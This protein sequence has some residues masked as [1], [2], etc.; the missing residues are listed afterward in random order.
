MKSR[1]QLAIGIAVAAALV[2]FAVVIWVDRMQ[3]VTITITSPTEAPISVSITGAVR[4][5]GVVEVPAGSRLQ[6]V[7]EA[8]GG[9]RDDA[10]T[11]RLNMAGRVG[12]GEQIDI[13]VVGAAEAAQ[14]ERQATGDLIDLNTATISELDDLPGIGEVLAGRIIDYRTTNGPFTA[15]DEL[16]N[17]EGISPRLVDE[18]RPHVTVSPGG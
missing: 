11:D 15:V 12:D 1:V 8:A 2:V 9:L 13:P 6:E 5:P 3:P 7:I 14:A 4:S 16:S 10:D 18:I 17:I